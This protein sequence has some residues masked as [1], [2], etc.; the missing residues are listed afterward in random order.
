MEGFEYSGIWWLP[1]D[2][3]KR[4]AGTLKFDPKE[5]SRLDLIGTFKELKDLNVFREPKIILG[6]TSNGKYITLYKC[7]ET[8]FN[9]NFP[10]FSNSSFLIGMV[11]VGCHFAKE[12]DILFNSLSISYSN[13]DE[14]AGISGFKQKTEFNQ[15]SHLIKFDILYEPPQKIEA[16]L[17]KYKAHITFNFNSK[18]DLIYEFNL[19]QTTLFKMESAAPT[20]FNSYIDE[21]AG[22]ARDFFSLAIGKAIYPKMIIGK[23]NASFIK[24]PDGEIVFN[25]ILIFYKLG[26]FV[27]FSKRVLRHEMLFTYKDISDNFELYLNNWVNKSELLQPVYE[28]YFGTLYNPAMYLNHQFLS[29]AQALESYHRRRYEGKYVSDD[30]NIKQYQSFINAILKEIESSFKDSLCNKIKYLHEF[31]LRKRLNDIFNRYGKMVRSIIPDVATFIESVKNTR[32]FLTHYD[33]NLELKSKKG[34]DLYWLTQKMKCLLEICLLSELGI[35]DETIKAILSRN[36]RYKFLAQ[37]EISPVTS[38]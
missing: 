36:E 30:D 5:G 35:P 2:P 22:Y 1:E 8:K 11:I 7:I 9:I 25:D 24:L 29:L 27:D 12:E 37:Q 33:K 32:D 26:P 14:W 20:N 23:S 3:E 19:K 4:A 21:I 28:L 17:G 10:G 34:R 31:S 6:L 13:L 38:T 16:D 15:E 18:S